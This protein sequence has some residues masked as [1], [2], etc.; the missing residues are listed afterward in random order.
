MSRLVLPLLGGSLAVLFYGTVLDDVFAGWVD[1][2][3]IAA[4]G[5]QWGIPI[6]IY[7][8]TIVGAGSPAGLLVVVGYAFHTLAALA[9]AVTFIRRGRG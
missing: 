8:G 1:L 4:L 9:V 5:G 6:G 3:T 7:L 2:L